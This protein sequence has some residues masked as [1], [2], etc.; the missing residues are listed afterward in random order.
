MSRDE[1][2]EMSREDAIGI[3]GSGYVRIEEKSQIGLEDLME[4]IGPERFERARRLA[5]ITAPY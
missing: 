5:W 3:F 4:A 1:E 2:S